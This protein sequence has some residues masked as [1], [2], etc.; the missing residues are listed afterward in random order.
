M[1]AT[2]LSAGRIMKRF[3]AFLW[4]RLARS[5]PW[6]CRVSY[7]QFG[8]GMILARLFRGRRDPGFYLDV[9]AY[10]PIQLSNTYSLYCQGW[11]GICVEPR[12]EVVEEFRVFRSRDICL[13]VAV[14]PVPAGQIE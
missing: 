14:T 4:P 9:G 6:S 2:M 8:E 11:R 12:A 13:Q 1:C 3:K 5:L 7:S 10:H